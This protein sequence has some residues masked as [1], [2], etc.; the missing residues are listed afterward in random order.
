MPDENPGLYP[1][2]LRPLLRIFFRHLYHDQAWIYD[3]VANAVS[4]GQWFRWVELPLDF[5]LGSRI[6]ELGCGTGHLTARLMQRPEITVAALDE[7]A[8]MLQLT[9]QRLKE[10]GNA[11]SSLVQGRAQALPWRDSSFDTVIATFPTEFI[12]EDATLRGMY[13]VLA[14]GG[15][16]IVLPAAWLS[17]RKPLQQLSAALF[18]AT[19]QVTPSPEAPI[20]ARLAGPLENLGFSVSLHRI[21]VRGS[22]ALLI[23]AD[24]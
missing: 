13:R 15:R 8:E 6:L 1:T 17:V 22:T 21:E 4:L 14:R 24:K 16:L 18:T 20:V 11:S 23:S 7:S 19:R 3:I 10:F 5:I 9:R 12:S 2:I